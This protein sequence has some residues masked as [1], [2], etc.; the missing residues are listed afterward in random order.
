MKLP[1]LKMPLM[2]E[3]MAYLLFIWIIPAVFTLFILSFLIVKP[4]KSLIKMVKGED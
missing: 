1:K 3:I 2:S 4:I